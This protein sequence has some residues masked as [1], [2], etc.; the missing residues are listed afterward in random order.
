[1]P[2]LTSDAWADWTTSGGRVE[3]KR[4]PNSNNVDRKF[5]ASTGEVFRSWKE[6]QRFLETGN[7]RELKEQLPDKKEDSLAQVNTDTSEYPVKQP[8]EKQ[9]GSVAQLQPASNLK[10]HARDKSRSNAPSADKKVKLES[11]RAQRAPATV[12]AEED[13][14]EEAYDEDFITV[15]KTRTAESEEMALTMTTSGAPASKVQHRNVVDLTLHDDNGRVQPPEA[16]TDMALFLS[17]IILPED[18]LNKSKGAW[19]NGFGPVEGWYI[20]GYDEAEPRIVFTTTSAEY[21]AQKPS[22][23]FRKIL[24]RLKAGAS[25]CHAVYK[26][27]SPS[28]LPKGDPDLSIDDL[29]V[30]LARGSATKA[31]LSRETVLEHGRFLLQQLRDLDQSDDGQEEVQLASL[32]AVSALEAML[33]AREADQSAIHVYKKPGA[34][35]IKDKKDGTNASTS[36]EEEDDDLKL[37][38]KLQAQE[39]AKLAGQAKKY[40][41]QLASY[42]KSKAGTYIKMNESE[43]ADDYPPPAYYMKTDEEA[44]EYMLFEDYAEELLPEELPRHQLDDFAFYNM[45]GRMVS[46]ELLPMWSGVDPDI[47]LYG[48]GNMT[49]GRGEDD[50]SGGE[51]VEPASATTATGVSTTI[52]TEAVGSSSG[53]STDAAPQAAEGHAGMRV[54]LSA[55]KEWVVEFGA[56]MVFVTVR[57]DGAWYRLGKSSPQ[58]Q[59]WYAPVIKTARVAVQCITALKDEARVARLS[60]GQMAQHL[61]KMDSTAAAFI[62]NKVAEVERLLI[63]HGQIILNVFRTFP[64]QT[65]QRCQFV[66]TLQERMLQRSHTKLTQTKKQVVVRRTRNANP[67]AGKAP[68]AYK[69]KPMRATMTPLVHRVFANYFA[70]GKVDET[71]PVAA[72]AVEEEEAL[73]DKGDDDAEDEDS[74]AAPPTAPSPARNKGKKR[75][76]QAQDAQLLGKPTGDEKLYTRASVHGVEIAAGDAVHLPM[77]D[78]DGAM[79]RYGVVQYFVLDEER[80]PTAAVKRLAFGHETV[81][82]E[83]ADERELFLTEATADYDLADITACNNVKRRYRPWGLDYLK[84]NAALDEKV[85]EEAEQRGAGEEL[86]YY[87]QFAYYAHRGGFFTLPSMSDVIENYQLRQEEEKFGS[88]Q[89]IAVKADEFTIKGHTYTIGDF[90]FIAADTFQDMKKASKGGDNA[91]DCSKGRW[92]IGSQAYPIVEIL[93]LI[94]PAKGVASASKLKV[95]RYFRGEDISDARAYTGDIRE[96]YFTEMTADVG[97]DAVEGPCVVQRKEAVF[98][99]DAFLEEHNTFHCSYKFNPADESIHKLDI[100]HTF[101]KSASNPAGA[102]KGKALARSISNKGKAVVTDEDNDRH[103][104]ATMDIFAGCGGLSE[105]LQQSGVTRTKWAVEYDSAAADAFRLNNPDAAMFCENC[106]VVLRRLMEK[107]GASDS[108]MSTPEAD[109]G[110]AAMSEADAARLPSPGEVD[111]INGGPP[112]QGFSGMN[113]FNS[114]TWSRVQ[115]EMVL[116]F[117]SFADYLRPRFFLLEN[118]R[119]FVT[120]NKSQIF[121]LTLRALLEMGYQVRFA[122]LQAGH[123]GVAQSRKRTIIWA[124]APD[125]TLPEW[126]E[127]MHVFH[128]TQLSVP[129]SEGQRY[130]AVRESARGAPLRAVTVKDAIAD[131]PPVGNGA[132]KEVLEYQGEPVSFFQKRIRNGETVL[133]DHIAKAMNELNYLRC[134]NVPVRPQPTPCFYDW[135]DLQELPDDRRMVTLSDGKKVDLV[136][137]C[138]PNTAAKHNQWKGL[139]GRLDWDG[140]FPTA[141]TDP[142][143]MGKVGMCFHPDQHRIVTVR[144]CARAQGFPD[145]FKFSGTIQNKHRQIG[146]AVPPPLAYALGKMLK[147]VVSQI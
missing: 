64:D 60:F 8:T 92:N 116:A 106:N 95:R 54:F 105:G 46:L 18:S 66:T 130:S 11:S 82:S 141:I 29:L 76:V 55:I 77:D 65:V 30:K 26:L 3:E 140:N 23:R 51:E 59:G 67:L 24:T 131:L 40:T 48:S 69:R 121:R 120:H 61:S 125:E 139:F 71:A 117:L 73:D 38:R 43:L 88:A 79:Q 97:I 63:V 7:K 42:N 147:K 128:S 119:N 114:G 83:A 21:T 93:H 39:E 31:K 99:L 126:P 112:C 74:V 89:R 57:T 25:V 16:I 13:D 49:L 118:V 146:N 98:D 56:G 70:Q 103:R 35:V 36:S 34:L 104:L 45:D 32:P 108:C 129:L 5:V 132:D 94:M 53:C 137:W 75:K 2:G 100:T 113:R 15:I 124:A 58:Y 72:D 50:W 12:Y 27:L 136:P 33:V 91:K 144:E 102:G 80:T 87:Y 1:M 110:A 17:A 68:D 81:L 10:R 145:S 138:L 111:F 86:S 107:G 142:Q 123:Y 143:P 19:C 78:E 84:S 96:V 85:K 62:S 14:T 37:A 134:Q 127:P 44:D 22:A 20:D 9:N 101:A 28:A 47:E 90:V 41:K 52:A 115:C 6:C 109:A 4:R 133:R 122:I 135:R